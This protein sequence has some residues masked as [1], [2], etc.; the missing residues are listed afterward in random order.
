MS[1]LNDEIENLKNK[2]SLNNQGSQANTPGVKEIISKFSSQLKSNDRTNNKSRINSPNIPSLLV[3]SNTDCINKNRNSVY[4]DAENK[5]DNTG[6]N[7]NHSVGNNNDN[8]GT[9]CNDVKYPDVEVL[10]SECLAIELNDVDDC[11]SD[12]NDK[13]SVFSD[14]KSQLYTGCKDNSKILHKYIK[15][16]NSITSNNF[17]SRNFYN[18]SNSHRI[19]SRENNNYHH[20]V[21]RSGYNQNPNPQP[22]LSWRREDQYYNSE[23]NRYP[24]FSTLRTTTHHIRAA[25]NLSGNCVSLFVSRID[26]EETIE[27]VRNHVLATFGRRT[28]INITKLRSKYSTYSSFKI[29][30]FNLSRRINVFENRHWPEGILVKNFR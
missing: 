21:S 6:N 18:R 17:K 30:I 14:N 23:K 24:S 1:T 9:N 27:A 13:D 15:S 16:N 3:S 2:P 7:D 29:D 8:S 19:R 28:E 20:Q 4:V 26:P 10:K 11:K 5:S 22:E 12:I 25:P